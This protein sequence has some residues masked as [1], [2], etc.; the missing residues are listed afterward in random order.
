MYSTAVLA[1]LFFLF[2][3][4]VWYL[5]IS[6]KTHDKVIEKVEKFKKKQFGR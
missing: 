5:L 2:L 6:A 4:F 3:I 1:I